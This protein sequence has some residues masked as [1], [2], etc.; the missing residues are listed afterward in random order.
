MIS[1]L[2]AT[3]HVLGLLSSMHAIMTTRTSQG[4]IAWAVSL[5]T[6]PYVAVPAYWV[7]GRRK[8]EG[9]VETFQEREEE[10][11]H[12]FRTL[13]ENLAPFLI[14]SRERI[15]NYEGIKALAGTGLIGGN[16]VELLV[17]GE[18]TFDSLLEGIERAEKYVLV[19]F[20]IVRDDGLGRR[21][22]EALM[23]KAR[24][25]LEVIFVYDEIGSKKL[26]ESY[27]EDLRAAGAEIAAFNTRQG[28][29]NRF[30]LNFRNHRKIV[31]VDG[32]EAWIGGHNV[33]DEYLGL[34]PEMS[35]WRDTHMRLRG[36]AALL[37]QVTVLEDWYWATRSIPDIDW[38][39]VAS[40]VSDTPALV[41]ATGPADRLETAS[42]F[43]LH[44]INSA[45]ERIW[46]ATP[47]F[48]PE[49]GIVQALQLAALR[50]VDVRIILPRNPDQFM[51]WLSSFW[52]IEELA[53]VDVHFY[54]YDEGFMHQKV[55]LV[56]DNVSSIGTANFDNRSFRLNFEVTSLVV[57]EAFAAEVEQMLL[58]DLDRS[59]PFD[60]ATLSE[61]PFH[62][63]LAIRVSRLMAPIQ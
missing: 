37:A 28:R 11:E 63:R 30:Q 59:T 54:H 56:D 21:L 46:I 8:F 29:R 39:P 31:V 48:V 42:L 1:L 45:Q 53:P 10:V 40:D 62:R 61:L 6:F 38:V 5:N 22:K 50:G 27:R 51:V 52:F 34:D 35:P 25:G 18:A 24:E 17:D 58:D 26:P 12:L 43:F 44:A 57:D 15:P 9:Y 20:Y 19:E 47:Y 14:E 4:A 23:A 32:V 60:P 41:L 36:P 3:A 16:E 33:G 55:M 49:E 2:L 7:F 13:H